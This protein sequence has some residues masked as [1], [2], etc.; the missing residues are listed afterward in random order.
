VRVEV[1]DTRAE[2]L[3]RCP[4]TPDA[5]RPEESGRGLLL[6]SGLAAR[7]DWHARRDGSGKIVWAEY[8]LR[9]R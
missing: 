4:D 5:V 8:V 6:V 9:E 1:T 3:S 2:R 7:W